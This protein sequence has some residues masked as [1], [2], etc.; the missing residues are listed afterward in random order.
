MLNT[1]LL[2]AALAPSQGAAG[3]KLPVGRDTTRAA[4]P[5]LA[6]GTVDYRTALNRRLAKG[7]TP[8]NN[9]YTL[10]RKAFRPGGFVDLYDYAAAEFGTTPDDYDTL[11][12]EQ[13]RAARRPWSA[14]GLPRV[15]KWLAASGRSLAVAV[16][17]SRRP[18]YFCPAVGPAGTVRLVDTLLPTGRQKPADLVSALTCRAMLRL[19]D[20]QYDAAWT[21]LIAAHRLA[22][23]IGHGGTILNGLIGL[24]AERKVWRAELAF[25][26]AGPHPAGRLRRCLNDL[27]SLPSGG[28]AARQIDLGERFLMLEVVQHAHAGRLGAMAGEVPADMSPSDWVEVMRAGNRLYDRAV[29]AVQMEPAARRRAFAKIEA[30]LK[31]MK[32]GGK[33]PA[34]AAKLIG[35]TFKSFRRALAGYDRQ[36]EQFR[37]VIAAF[38]E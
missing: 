12:D 22:R 17:A 23:L 19:G 20:K 32:A 15:A 33:A 5:M 38:A 27:Q 2:L 30:D 28:D 1:T 6:D 13:D 25:R 29:A 35:G 31:A 18:Q 11:A 37:K 4:G 9:A 14:A 16:E 3:P 24:D 21:D 8:Q 36:Q 26:A 10:L 7:V 34:A